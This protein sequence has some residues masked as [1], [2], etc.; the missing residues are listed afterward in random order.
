MKSLDLHGLKSISFVFAKFSFIL[1]VTAYSFTFL[2][3]SK[4]DGTEGG[5][6]VQEGGRGGDTLM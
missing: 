6:A 4:G 2:T 1:F 3:W 5:L